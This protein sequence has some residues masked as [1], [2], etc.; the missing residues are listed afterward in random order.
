MELIEFDKDG[1]INSINQLSSKHK[2][3]LS[4]I[5]SAEEFKEYIENNDF[6]K[7]YDY[8][9]RNTQLFNYRLTSILLLSN[10]DI[11]KHLSRIPDN[12]FYSLPILNITIPTN[13]IKIGSDAF[14]S[15]KTLNT[16]YIPKTVKFIDWYVFSNSNIKEINF[17]VSEEEAYDIFN[18]RVS[19]S[20]FKKYLGTD[21]GAGK[22]V[23]LN[24]NVKRD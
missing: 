18:G 22:S 12:C 23:K 21:I 7:A 4:N 5:F 15:V 24:F 16:I 3:D 13:I 17:E 19:F 2:E 8:F 10:I 9:D 1:L 20:A 6:D 11:L 14:S